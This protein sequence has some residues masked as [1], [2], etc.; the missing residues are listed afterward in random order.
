MISFP[1]SFSIFY[2]LVLGY[3]VYRIS[4]G[5]LVCWV[6]YSILEQLY[7]LMLITRFK[8]PARL[9]TRA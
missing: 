6:L 8:V 5:C 7:L 4:I 1:V 9:G 2:K 3:G